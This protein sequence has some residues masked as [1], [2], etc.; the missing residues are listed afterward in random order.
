MRLKMR[1]W[2][3]DETYGP[4]VASIIGL[5]DKTDEEALTDVTYALEAL[6]SETLPDGALTRRRSEALHRL[7]RHA[8]PSLVSRTLLSWRLDLEDRIIR[9]I[10]QRQDLKT[11]RSGIECVYPTPIL[12]Q[13][14]AFG[15]H[16]FS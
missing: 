16:R 2:L 15:L 13:R 10:Q 8:K 14:C 5:R 6:A 11:R 1:R 7:G 3:N 4:R 12:S 9:S